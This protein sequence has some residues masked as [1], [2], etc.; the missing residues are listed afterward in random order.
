MPRKRRDGPPRKPYNGGMKQKVAFLVLVLIV[1]GFG[2]VF[3]YDTNNVY[4][5]LR[6][7]ND[8]DI[9][10]AKS[11]LKREI[12]SLGDTAVVDDPDDADV[13]IS[14]MII[15]ELFKRDEDDI[16]GYA[17]TARFLSR[18]RAFTR[19]VYDDLIKKS[20]SVVGAQAAYGIWMYPEQ[21]FAYGGPSSLRFICESLVVRLDN[22]I[23]YW[24]R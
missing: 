13:L 19:M 12:R 16:S 23:D 17:G 7:S 4:L 22:Y 6:C 3:A 9:A 5:Q 24:F 14:V 15:R 18:E 1:A 11:F 10:T 21:T 8:D 2:S 20:F